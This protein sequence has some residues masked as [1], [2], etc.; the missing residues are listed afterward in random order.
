MISA[1]L[2][3][4]AVA[5]PS[6]DTGAGTARTLGQADGRFAFGVFRPWSLALGERTELSTTGLIGTFIAPRLDVKQ[7]LART[8]DS[9]LAL[10]AGVAVPMTSLRLSKGWLY[11]DDAVIPFSAIGKLGILASVELDRLRVTA[12][13]DLRV[14]ATAGPSSLSRRDLFFFD[15]AMAPLQEGPVTSTLKLQLDYHPTDRWLVT[16]ELA[17]QLVG[18]RPQYLGRV[19]GLW[20]FSGWGA[21]GAGVFTNHIPRDLGYESYFIPGAD[22]QFRL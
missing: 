10:V 11:P 19:F 13:A 1:L 21:L 2:M 14:G 17:T 9:A 7:Q 3:T 18:T 20:G 12:G 22:L 6:L 16:A 4:T 8:E 5:A 15:W